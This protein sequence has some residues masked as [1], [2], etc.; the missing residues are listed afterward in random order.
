MLNHKAGR[1]E[2][3]MS[4]KTIIVDKK[5]RVGIVTL[6]RPAELNTFNTQLAQ[7][8]NTALRELDGDSSIRVVVIKG[9]GK[10]FCAGIDLKEMPGKG[11]IELR[12]WIRDMDEHNVT[13]A[14]MEK[15][16][17][18]CVHGAAVANGMGLACACDLTVA[19]E[20]AK[21]GTTAINVGLYCFGP[22][23]PLSRC[24]GK[25]RALE[26]LMTGE[27]VDAKRALEFGIVNRLV[28]KEVLEKEAMALAG[29]LAE[30]SPLALKM[31]KRSY[32][33]MSN[34]GYNEAL[35]YLGEAF[36]LLC[37]TEDAKEGVDAFL[38]K[39]EPKWKER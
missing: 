21:F 33:A 22:S 29:E 25:K 7:E 34:M 2:R 13:I 27:V 39:R 32:Y 18:A 30:K 26:L 11:T 10:H 36:T 5:D 1:K 37:C 20:D 16:V 31:A 14:R 28:A 35:T 9:E 8:L 23:A 15:P 38:N 3:T 6:N 4:Y 19:S 24:V 17:I 12:N